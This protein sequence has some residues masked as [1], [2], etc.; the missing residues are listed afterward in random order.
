MKQ[1]LM[2]W[3]AQASIVI[4]DDEP[5]MTKI[6]K[7]VLENEGYSVRAFNKPAEALKSIFEDPPELI[8]S[9]IRMPKLSGF[10]LLKQVKEHDPKISVVLLT[11][12]GSVDSAVQAMQL[13]ADDYVTKPFQTDDLLAKVEKAVQHRSLLEEVQA[14]SAHVSRESAEIKLIGQSAQLQEIHDTIKKSGPTDSSILVSGE[15]GTGKELVA[16]AIHRASPRVTQ[17]FVPINC[18]SIP[19]MLLESELFGYEKG[20]FT[21][22]NQRKIGLIELASGGTLFLDE[23]GEL[24]L[25]LQPKLLRMLQEKEIQRVG[26]LKPISVDIRL[27]TATNRSLKEAI[28]EGRFRQDLYFRLNV[29]N[30]HV[31]PLRERVEDIQNLLEHYTEML[32]KR[33]KNKTITLHEAA[34][35]ILLKYPWPGNVR[36]L[37]NVLERTIVLLEGDEINVDDLPLEIHNPGAA[38]DPKVEPGAESPALEYRQALAIFEQQYFA[39]LLTESDGN[40]SEAAR[41]AGISRRN[42]YDK[43]D[44]LGIASKDFKNQED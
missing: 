43:L 6:L 18:A 22:A 25:N 37:A 42:F 7:R 4:V 11:A 12:F 30:I 31:P 5:N 41:R 44:K 29:I 3:T 32:G 13:G 19:E 17:R 10:D 2:L 14:L 28:D 15:S 35:D 27:V 24:P 40:V 21:G 39:Q 23:I 36:E 33:L 9:D 26:G 20:A 34:A 38:T 16:Q 1:K 8:L